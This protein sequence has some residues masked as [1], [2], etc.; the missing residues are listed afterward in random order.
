M[1]P[2]EAKYGANFLFTTV[3][4]AMI[5]Q[6]LLTYHVFLERPYIDSDQRQLSFHLK[7]LAALMGLGT[8]GSV[9]RLAK[10]RGESRARSKD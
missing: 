6:K 1:P 2:F 7:R 3:C 9:V 4:L 10:R 5:F 8:I